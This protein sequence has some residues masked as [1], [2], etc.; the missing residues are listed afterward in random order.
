MLLAIYQ[1]LGVLEYLDEALVALGLGR[2]VVRLVELCTKDLVD[3]SCL[4][5]VSDRGK[6][7]TDA[8]SLVSASRLQ[9]VLLHYFLCKVLL[10]TVLRLNVMQ[11]FVQV[12]GPASVCGMTAI[13]MHTA[14]APA[15]VLATIEGK[16]ASGHA[17]IVLSALAL[18]KLGRWLIFS[19]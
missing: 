12:V 16:S 7:G 8:L 4:L 19:N 15:R 18:D 10:V 13:G 14:V 9:C 6:H 2:L 1:A 5:H 11:L 17:E 3:A